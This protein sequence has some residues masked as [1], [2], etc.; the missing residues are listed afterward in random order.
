[1]DNIINQLYELGAVKFGSFT[2]KNGTLSPFYIDLRLIVSSPKLLSGIAQTIALATQDIHYDL[3][4]GVPYTAIP[5][6]TAL[7]LIKETP[8][9]LKRKERK[10]YGT[11]KILEG[12]F[13][14]GQQCLVIEDVITSGQSILETIDTLQAEGLIVQDIAVLVDREQGGK[15]RLEDRGLE[16][17]SIFTISEIVESLLQQGKIDAAQAASIQTFIKI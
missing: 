8:M 13:Q 12:I 10:E 3:L 1:M 9:I 11:G 2:L 16:V 6:A 4:C 15:K 5:F 17:H 14:K 7:S